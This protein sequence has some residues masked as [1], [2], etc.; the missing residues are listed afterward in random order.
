MLIYFLESDIR[1]IL[2]K[3]WISVSRLVLCETVPHVVI[4]SWDTKVEVEIL[5]LR[6]LLLKESRTERPDK[7]SI[8]IRNYIVEELSYKLRFEV[9]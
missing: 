7:A 2:I 6:Q 4:K 3:Y 1:M 9:C 8:V 5:I